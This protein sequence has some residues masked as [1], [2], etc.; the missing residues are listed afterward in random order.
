MTVSATTNNQCSRHVGDT[1]RLAVAVLSGDARCRK[2]SS[3][4]RNCHDGFPKLVQD[5]AFPSFLDCFNVNYQTYPINNVSVYCESYLRQNVCIVKRGITRE[6]ENRITGGIVFRRIKKYI[7]I[8]SKPIFRPNPKFE[9][10][11]IWDMVRIWAWTEY[12]F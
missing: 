11:P 12:I 5:S 6:K 2:S 10:I 9:S 3:E 4:L 8:L 7:F 1:E